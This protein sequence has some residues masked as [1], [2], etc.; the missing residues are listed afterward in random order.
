[1]LRPRHR[2]K[3]GG[4]GLRAGPG[5]RLVRASV[6][7]IDDAM[8]GLEEFGTDDYAPKL[9]HRGRGFMDPLALWRALCFHLFAALFSLLCTH[10]HCTLLRNHPLVRA[11]GRTTG[12]HKFVRFTGIACQ[13][14]L[15]KQL[16]Q[17]EMSIRKLH[18]LRGIRRR[19][20]QICSNYRKQQTFDTDNTGGTKSYIAPASK[21]IEIRL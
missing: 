13:L 5:E 16:P 17:Q 3:S 2:L 20:K 18:Y 19:R 6:P 14:S 21:E 9:S 7:T 4:R 10:P 15:Y 1:M 12:S 8:I 11:G